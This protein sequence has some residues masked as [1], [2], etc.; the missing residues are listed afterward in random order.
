MICSV[1]FQMSAMISNLRHGI[2]HGR[3]GTEQTDYIIQARICGIEH[4]DE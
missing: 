4:I 3:H 2:R 1:D